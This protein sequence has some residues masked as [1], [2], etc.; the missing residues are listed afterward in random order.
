MNSFDIEKALETLE[1]DDK[2]DNL[3]KD[4][5]IKIIKTSGDNISEK[6]LS[7]QDTGS[8]ELR[9]DSQIYLQK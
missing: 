3:Y 4:I 5:I 9:E 6:N 2:V 8:K 7:K 1:S